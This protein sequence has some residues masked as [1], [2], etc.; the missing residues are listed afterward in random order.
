MEQHLARSAWFAGDAYS[1]AD[2]ALFAYTHVA[3]TG[4]LDL[5][6]FPAIQGW[7][8]RVREQPAIIAMPNR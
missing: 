4:G 6:Q 1:V 7:P 2:I 3:E 5:G 8:Q